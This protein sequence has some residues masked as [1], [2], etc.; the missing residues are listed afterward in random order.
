[1]WSYL[2]VFLSPLLYQ[3][4]NHPIPYP[5]LKVEYIPIEALSFKKGK[6]VVVNNGTK[7]KALSF[8]GKI[9]ARLE[10]Q[11]DELWWIL[12]RI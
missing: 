4:S 11:N 10:E 9:G 6:G 1:M 7:D 12:F 3:D 2:I 8:S 5:R